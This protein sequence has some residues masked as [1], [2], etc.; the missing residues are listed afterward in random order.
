MLTIEK[1]VVALSVTCGWMLAAGSAFAGTHPLNDAIYADAVSYWDFDEG[2]GDIAY[3]ANGPRDATLYR[4]S[5]WVDGVSGTAVE[6]DWVDN[7]YLG[8]TPLIYTNTQPWSWAMWQ[9]TAR[10]D[11][12]GIIGSAAQYN[13]TPGYPHLGYFLWHSTGKLAVYF[14][15]GASAFI[16]YFNDVVLGTEASTTDWF[17]VAVACETNSDGTVDLHA[18]INGTNE[19]THTSVS[20]REGKW[21][22]H[23]IGNDWRKFAGQMDE[24]AIWDRTLTA[25]E[26]QKLTLIAPVPST[27]LMISVGIVALLV[28]RRKRLRSD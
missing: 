28:T 7:G 27:M 23:E 2:T 1:T 4:S 18:Y 17:H 13:G 5:N 19:Q 15:S 25:D 24:V 26:I 22:F 6:T 10:L 12:N 9:K 3:D 14:E 20:L 16:L 21:R 8:H 11:W